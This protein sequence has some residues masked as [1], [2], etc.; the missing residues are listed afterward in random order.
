MNAVGTLNLLEATRRHAPDAVFI[1]VSTN[2]VYGD[3]PNRVPL[4]ELDTRYDYADP[5]FEQGIDETMSIDGCLHSL[6][7]A[8]KVAADVL[9]Q[10]YGRYFGM[11]TGAFR[12]GCLTGPAPLRRRAARLPELPRAHGAARGRVHDL[13]LQG[14]A[15][16]RPDP[17]GRRR[18][19]RSGPSRRTPDRGEVYNL[20][21]GK[22]NAASLLECVELIAEA[23]GGKR[24]GLTYDDQARVGDHICYYTDMAKFRAHYPGW[25]RS[26]TC[27]PSSSRWWARCT[28]SSAELML[29]CRCA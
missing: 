5:A 3:N 8:S 22:A 14:E 28:A 12:G 9:T 1:T 11:R 10:E 23:S 4:V 15:G 17:L 20:G 7:G 16:P 25:R 19:A 2:K 21:G 18:S 27:R 24:P 29:P 6:F 26:T 13:R